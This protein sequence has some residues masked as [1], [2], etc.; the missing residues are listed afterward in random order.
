[1]KANSVDFVFV[2]N[3]PPK[4]RAEAEAGFERLIQALAGVGLA[5]EVRHGNKNSLFIFVKLASFDLLAQQVYRARLQDWL[6]GVRSS[7]PDKDVKRSFEDE[8]IT[9]AERLRLVY[10]MITKPTDDGGAG[11]LPGADKWKYLDSVF[12]LHNHE[13]NKA[14]IQ[15]WSKKYLLDQEDLDE[16]RNKFGE[17]VAF[18]FAFVQSYFKFLVFPAAAGFAAWMLLGQFSVFYALL[19]CL[20]SV[21]FFE[22]WKQREVD[23][24]VQWGTRGVSSIQHQ[25][26]DFKW[27]YEVEDPVTG[28]PK[29]VYSPYLRFRTQALQIPFALACILVLGSLVVTCNSLEIFINEVYNGP[30]KQYLVSLLRPVRFGRL[31]NRIR[32]FFQP[33]YSSYLLLLSR[34]CS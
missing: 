3:I 10:L 19:S 26:P 6:H 23:L 27:E 13:F 4:E 18:Y 1:M 20:W 30:F 31:L 29:K 16:I 21:V 15:K 5:T 33:F 12:P 7:A 24:A 32:P 17:T 25:R 28:E 2:Y 22:Y 11:I 14:W 34:Q 9:E 8:P